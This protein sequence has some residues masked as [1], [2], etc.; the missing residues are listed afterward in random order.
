ML[1]ELTT[2]SADAIVEYRRRKRAH[3]EQ[4]FRQDEREYALSQGWTLVRENAQSLR[5]QKLR[6]IDEQLENEFWRLLYE[7]GYPTLS[8]GRNFQI[9]IA[10]KDE[11]DVTKQIDV[12]AYDHETIIVAECKACDKRTKRSLSKDIGELA[13][14]Q[15]P[16]SLTLRKYF[17]GK[18]NQKVIWIFVTKNVDWIE[19][20]RVKAREQNINIIT[21][22]EMF[23]YKEIAKRIGHAARYQFQAEFL[24]KAKVA[25][26]EHETFAIRTKL[27]PLKVFSFFAPARKILPISFINHRDLRDPTATPSYQRLIQK[28]RLKQIAD[29]LNEG[30]F[31]PNSIILN[32]KQR[33]RFDAHKPEN[34]DGV[35]SGTLVLP[36]TYKSAWIIDGQHRIYGY[37]EMDQKKPPLLPFIAFENITITEETKL[38]TEINSK[39][40]RVEKRLLDELTGEIKL[41]SA[42]RREQM[43]AIGSRVFDIM[44]DDDDGPLGGKITGA[45]L[46]QSDQSVLTIPYLVD[47][48]NQ[49]ALLGR[50]VTKEGK[51]VFMQGPLHWEKPR[52]AIDTLLEFLTDPCAFQKREF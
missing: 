36:N 1:G 33:V 35:T 38:F 52:E 30:G 3:I 23:Y 13:S 25:A 43:R 17:G 9:T 15:R 22:R 27:G 6:G 26:L 31:F 19:N 50:V 21:E 20:D 8:V 2:S 18:F 16:I 12:F 24:A 37:A 41:E 39:Q 7:L 45:E 34:E 14:L 10:S 46:K 49:G 51:N 28:P 40:K 42:D 48:V 47:A 29:F 11:G 5:F 4:T 32:F 44:R